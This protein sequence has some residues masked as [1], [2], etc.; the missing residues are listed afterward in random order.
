M[1][2]REK[3]VEELTK[4]NVVLT[5]DNKVVSSDGSTLR[6]VYGEPPE[7]V[8][9]MLGKEEAEDQTLRMLLGFVSLELEARGGVP[10]EDAI[11]KHL[12]QMAP[13]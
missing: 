3:V 10:F 2:F 12:D 4:L 8:V 5:E 9:E 11:K 1:I 7:D 13:H 6:A